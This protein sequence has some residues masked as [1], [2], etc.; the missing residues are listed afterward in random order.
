MSNRYCEWQPIRLYA[1]GNQPALAK[2]WNCEPAWDVTAL[3]RR[4]D[5]EIPHPDFFRAQKEPAAECPDRGKVKYV[6]WNRHVDRRFHIEYPP[7]TKDMPR[8]Q[9]LAVKDPAREWEVI[10]ETR[11]RYLRDAGLTLQSPPEALAR[12]MAESFGAAS[13]FKDKPLCPAYP[14]AWARALDHG[15]EGVLYQSCCTGCAIGYAALADACGL[16]TRVIGMPGHVV[17]ESFAGGRWHMADSVGRHESHKGLDLYFEG[18]YMDTV[19]DPMG[20]HGRNL[21]HGFRCGLWRRPNPQFHLMGGQWLTSMTLNYGTQSAHALYPG[22]SRWGVTTRDPNRLTVILRSV[23]F[24]YPRVNKTFDDEPLRAIRAAAVPLRLPQKEEIRCD[25]LYHHLRPGERLR[26]SV[27]LGGL[28]DCEGIEVLFNF[29]ATA[30]SDFSE[31]TGRAVFVSVGEW[32]KSLHEL[33]AWPPAG[34]DATGNVSCVAR[35]PVDV[36]RA[37]AVNW[38][39]LEQHS[40]TTLY[41]AC[42]PACMEPY[43]A[44]LWSETEDTYGTARAEN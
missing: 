11:D 19:I 12:C 36:F 6:Y 27:Q 1:H 40:A 35:L 42:V 22:A 29:G 26:Q 16:P 13:Y 14:E 5:G 25:F 20:P 10:I 4:P 23:G 34:P 18:S 31:A 21:D 30:V 38:I 41:A 43:I 39:V 24:F 37:E 28:D 2:H 32:R 44:P 7:T 33:Q 8:H 9:G 3:H 15:V 17:A